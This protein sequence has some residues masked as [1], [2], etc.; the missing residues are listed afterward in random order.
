MN[1]AGSIH[2]ECRTV[3]LIHS[4]RL[5]LRGGKALLDDSCLSH[6]FIHSFLIMPSF[7]RPEPTC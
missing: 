4:S 1:E 5:A 2:P 6:S 3:A 7:V